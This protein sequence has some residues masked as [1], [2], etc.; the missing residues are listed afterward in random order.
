MRT[1]QRD[2]WDADIKRYVFSMLALVFIFVILVAGYRGWYQSYTASLSDHAHAFHLTSASHY[3]HA[4]EKLRIIEQDIMYHD[5][6][7]DLNAP[8]L[9]TRNH[10]NENLHWPLI[11]AVQEINQ[12]LAL[13][14][15]VNDARLAMLTNRINTLTAYFSNADHEII[16]SS[17]QRTHT[18][19]TLDQLLVTLNQIT[20]LHSSLYEETLYELTKM[21]KRFAHSFYIL[22]AILVF[23]SVLTTRRGLI[24]ISK[25]IEKHR[26]AEE[27]IQ[28]QAFY[29][30][31]TNLP[32]RLLSME[33]LSFLINEAKRKKQYVALLYIDLD[34]FKKVN[35]T[36]GHPVGDELLKQFAA[37]LRDSVR[38][39][40]TVGRLG[41]DEFVV[42]LGGLI[43]FE[44]VSLIAETLIT[45]A[46]QP[47]TIDGKELIVTASVGIAVYPDDG[48][49]AN[50]LLQRADSAM[51]HSKNSGRNMHSYFTDEMH[52]EV[53]R[54]LTLEQALR[55]AIERNEIGVF[56]QPQYDLSA[57]RIMGAEALL[58]W[59]HPTLGV[60]SPSEFIPIAEQSG[61]IIPLGKFVLAQALRM[62]YEWQSRYMEDFRISVNLSPR[63]FR[64]LTLVEHI[65]QS[66]EDSGISSK[67][68][69]LEIT[70]GVLIRGNHDVE[71]ALNAL[72]N[73]EISLA[74]DDFGTGYSSLSY[75]R[76]YPFNVVKI[77]QSFVRDIV[78]DPHDRE[79][80]NAA[81]RMAHSLKLRVIAE[82][83]ETEEQLA[84]LKALHCDFAQ[85]F[86]FSE[87][88]SADAMTVILAGNMSNRSVAG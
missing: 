33:R 67:H 9:T 20:R 56:Y 29:D 12:A 11:V 78:S 75:L 14:E 57:N 62:T 3:T 85:G 39:V 61:E 18:R 68:L 26:K 34:D 88:V 13:Q 21:D 79:L 51:Y 82:G 76:R 46:S 69:E 71:V 40:D 72:A 4:Q 38:A 84:Q 37:R 5:T 49:T 6:L 77:D 36:L 86:L 54:R 30:A 70:E 80:I 22:L 17:P 66:L 15:R 41:G 7:A 23:A 50:E 83:V 53:A 65:Q 47:Y 87:P 16:M 74:M 63:Q 35:D 45:R 24:T 25:I 1:K 59:Q 52:R 32:N 81:I 31:L 64:E 55:G 8:H 2:N 42:V 28:H 58:R 73:L 43:D 19:T 27:K 44:K 60:V 10:N 48:L